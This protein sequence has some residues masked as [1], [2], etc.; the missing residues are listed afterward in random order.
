MARL[1]CLVALGLCVFVLG[2]T[3]VEK[4]ARSAVLK[5]INDAK[6]LVDDAYTYSRA[7]TMRRVK[8]HIT[9]PTFLLR[10]VKQ[11][12]RDTRSA[13]RSA[14]YYEQT[15]QLL[16]KRHHVHRRSLNATDFLSEEDL[17]TIERLTG[18]TAR[19]RE[20]TCSSIPDVNEFRT[21]TSICNNKMKPRRGAS[22]I[23]FV[24]WLPAEYQDGLAL[25]QGWDPNLQRNGALLPL[26]RTVSNRI[27]ASRNEDV[28]NDDLYTHLITIFGQWTD[29]DLT[30]TPHSP[31]IISFNDNVMCDERCERTEPCFPMTIPPNDTGRRRHAECIPF[32][33]S[34][35]ACGTGNTGHI[36]GAATV[37]EQMNGITA[38][39]DVG[40]VYGSDEKLVRNLRDLTTDKGLLRVNERFSDNGREHLPFSNMTMM[41]ANREEIT[42]IDGAE[43]VPCFLAGDERVLENIGLASMHTLMMREHNRLARALGEMNPQW[44][45]ETIYQEAR[46][47]MGGY[48]QRITFRDY[49][50]HIV[51]P[52][53]LNGEELGP[54]PGY[55]EEV[56]PSIANVFATAAYRFAHTMVQPFLFR[57]DERYEEHPKWPSVLF[58]LQSFTPWRLVFEGGIDPIIRGLIGRQAKLNTQDTIIT[59]ELRDRLFEFLEEIAL[60]LAALNMQRG[61]DHGMPGYNSWRRF[62]GLSQPRTLEELAVV[63]NNT[64]LARSLLELYGTVDNI[65]IWLGGVA[66]PFVNGGR[67][68]PLFACL[69]SRQFQNIRVGDRLWWENEGVFTDA[70]RESLKSSSLARII[71][72]NTGI[73]DVPENPF[74]YRPR[75]AGYTKCQDIPAFDLSP[76]KDNS[77]GRVYN[78]GPAGPPGP[79][80]PPGPAGNVPKAAFAVRLG[81]NFPHPGKPIAFKSVIYNA[82]E[83]Y[84]IKTGVFTAVV[85]GVYQ[86]DFHCTLYQNVGNVDLRHNDQL[87]LHSFT[88]RHEGYVT[89]TGGTILQLA[90]GDRVYLSANYGGNGLTADSFFSGHILFT[91]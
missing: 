56:D 45:G 85:A 65:D 43:N 76:W 59:D 47:I 77:E 73:S 70:Q 75:G 28:I 62:C 12:A 67:V 15:M 11:P 5:A 21:A 53:I 40:Q 86:F 38:F 61:R 72:D 17:A 87:V 69:I 64:E 81:Y 66:E 7:E 22:N 33:Q 32:I 31:S 50:L 10:L 24:R 58:H 80:G 89:A 13:V 14:D 71:C 39:L 2:V 83:L 16:S 74:E 8:R 36:F 79:Q 44:T 55:D 4:P 1:L 68:G 60:D 78:R 26:V 3:S 91:A 34:A 51:G 49:L 82:Q 54:Y 41:C 27:L 23:P 48:A 46:K 42:G 35:P 63:L 6:K 30:F 18:C 57:L 25:P 19:I 37:K 84:N 20:P 90:A 88:T 29:H 52:D 9:N